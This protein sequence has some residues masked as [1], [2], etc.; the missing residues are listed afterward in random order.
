VRKEMRGREREEGRGKR[1]E[2]RGKREEGR[3]KREEGRGKREEGG[4]LH[5]WQRLSALLA[6]RGRRL[7]AN[8]VYATS[9]WF[10]IRSSPDFSKQLSFSGV[11]PEGDNYIRNNGST[12]LFQ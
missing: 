10:Q 11:D 6:P 12:N 5:T 8:K 9:P 1:E 4:S 3:G 7:R 2:G